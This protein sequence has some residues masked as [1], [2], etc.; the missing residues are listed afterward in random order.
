MA[1]IEQLLF[2]LTL[3]AA[4]GCGLVSGVFFAFSAFVMRALARLP[5]GEGIAAMQS[6]N[7]VVVRSWF[8]AAFMGTAAVCIIVLIYALFRLRESGA[9]YLLIGSVLYVVGSFL[10]T[11]VFNVP[12]N[13]ALSSVAPTDPNSASL[14]SDYVTNWT[15]W[16]HVRT[17]AS[18][19]AAGSFS[20]ALAY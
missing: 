4:L 17:V 1:I 10:V 20:I 16:N 6:I 5:A 12:R 11:I 13:E 18:L 8:M 7:V 3:L 14:W 15:A 19:A 2:A 9:I